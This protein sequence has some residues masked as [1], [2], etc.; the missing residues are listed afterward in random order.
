[1]IYPK[2]AEATITDNYDGKPYGRPND[3]VVSKSGGIYFSEPGPECHARPASADT[4]V[5]ASGVLR[6]RLAGRR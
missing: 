2:G 5:A 6:R 1:M 4:G 3:L